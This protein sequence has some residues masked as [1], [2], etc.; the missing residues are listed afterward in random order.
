MPSKHQSTIQIIMNSTHEPIDEV[1][2]NVRKAYRL[3]HDFQR[4]VRDAVSYIGAQLDSSS[5]L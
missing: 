5:T 3:L 4:M 1:F 2:L